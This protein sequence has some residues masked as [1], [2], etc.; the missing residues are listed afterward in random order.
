MAHDACRFS[1]G[2]S[3]RATEIEVC[4]SSSAFFDSCCKPKR[5]STPTVI[6]SPEKI[7][8]LNK[9]EFRAHSRKVLST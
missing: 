1:T 7:S 3:S 4:D 6:A 8:Y 9:R 2:V 5:L